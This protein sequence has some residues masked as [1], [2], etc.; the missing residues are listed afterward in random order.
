[1]KGGG[2]P[3]EEEKILT[4]PG[5]TVMDTIVPEFDELG[6]L[7]RV[8]FVDLFGGEFSPVS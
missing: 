7:I 2:N 6:L 4:G 3:V 5:V 1:M 8:L